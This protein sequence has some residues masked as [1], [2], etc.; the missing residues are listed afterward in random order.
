MP[1]ADAVNLVI[2]PSCKSVGG[3]VMKDVFSEELELFEAEAEELLS[4]F[5]QSETEAEAD[6]FEEALE[7]SA[8]EIVVD[9][10]LELTDE[11]PEVDVPFEV[12]LEDPGAA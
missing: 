1:I 4:V 6:E 3:L 8:G 7:F 12:E 11:I 10:G 5:P 2:G 9:E